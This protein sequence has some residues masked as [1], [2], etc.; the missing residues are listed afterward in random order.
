[1]FSKQILQP[2]V[3]FLPA[4]LAAAGEGLP[5]ND[6][7]SPGRHILHAARRAA[8]V[9]P[10]DGHLQPLLSLARKSRTVLDPRRQNG[11]LE[12]R[13]PLRTP[14]DTP[15]RAPLQERQHV[16]LRTR[17]RATSER[18][19]VAAAAAGRRRDRPVELPVRVQELVPVRY[20]PPADRG[21]FHARERN[22]A[23][24]RPGRAPG[25]RMQL[26]EARPVEGRGGGV[27]EEAGRLEFRSGRAAA[28]G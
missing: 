7:H 12:P 28:A 6:V 2:S 13:R 16:L 18:A 10:R 8:A 15:P 25:S 24:A 17:R 26:P 19:D 20:E 5:Q 4:V 27:E 21:H 3:R 23:S 11:P 14:G 9:R 1:M 22:R